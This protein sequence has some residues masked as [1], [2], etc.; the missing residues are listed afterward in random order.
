[1]AHRNEHVPNSN[2]SSHHGVTAYPFQT[3]RPLDD[4]DVTVTHV[5]ANFEPKPSA[6]VDSTSKTTP[7]MK[8]SALHMMSGSRGAGRF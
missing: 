6:P 2:V 7:R 8:S 1:M 5:T 4:H 3:I